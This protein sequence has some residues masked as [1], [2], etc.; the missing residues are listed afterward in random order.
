M[1]EVAV[2]SPA[3]QI[4]AIAGPVYLVMGLSILLYAKA[5]KTLMG[6]FKK[7]HLS[8]FGMML[9]SM[10]VGLFVIGMY[11]VWEWNVWL[12]VTVIG[13]AMFVKGL[14]YFLMPGEVLKS[15]ISLGENTGLLYLGGLVAIVLGGLL[16]YQVYF[17]A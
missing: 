9:A 12:I 5:W 15:L 7:D 16:S 10:A 1:E 17:V 8:L 2:M 11:N 14:L 4:A 6:K 3:A 13:W